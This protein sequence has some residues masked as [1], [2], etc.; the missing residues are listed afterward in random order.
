MNVWLICIGEP[1]PIDPGNQRY[2]RAGILASVLVSMG[3][4]VTWW[5]SAFDHSTKTQRTNHS[6][7]TIAADGMRLWLLR[8]VSYRRNIGLMRLINH[9]QVARQFRQLADTERIPDAI[10]CCWPS[11]ELGSAAVEYAQRNSV[12]IILDVRDLWPDIFLDPVPRVLRGIGRLLM[13]KYERMTRLAFS[14]ATGIIGI[15]QGY[16]DWGLVKAGRSRGSYDG[17]FPLGYD[18]P[19]ANERLAD[20]GLPGILANKL[21]HPGVICWFLGTFGNT[22]DLVPIIET[23]RK[24][25]ERGDHSALFVLSGHGDDSERYQNLSKDLTNVVFTG[26]LN[27][28]QISSMMQVENVAIAAYR[29]GAPQGLPNK[30]FEYMA[31]GLPILCSLD[32]ECKSFLSRHEC[33]ISYQAGDSEAFEAVLNS[34][35]NEPSLAKK[36]GSNGKNAFHEHYSSSIIYPRLAAHIL[37]LAAPRRTRAESPV[38]EYKLQNER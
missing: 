36:L 23:A 5:T 18:S 21:N 14:R 20:D 15:S 32:G 6:K 29:K 2:M 16:L 7:Q 17:L 37:N 9:A 27:A 11:I 12:P 34:V 25:E 1:L 33:G 8:G 13:A 30:I 3:H 38:F 28:D 24:L 26:W 22:Y 10:F 4:D 35:I 19:E 31:A